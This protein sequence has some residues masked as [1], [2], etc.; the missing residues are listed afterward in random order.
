MG[1]DLASSYVGCRVLATGHGA[2]LYSY[3]PINFAGIADTDTIWPELAAQAGYHGYLHPYVQ[4]PLWAWGL[5]PLCNHMRYPAFKHLFLLLALLSIAG[6]VLLTAHYWTPRLFHPVALAV[7]FTVL[8]FSEPFLFAMALVQTHALLLLLTVAGL[9]LAQ[10]DRPVAAGFC[11]AFAAAVK[12]TPGVVVLYWLAA[13]R[14]RAAASFL[15]WSVALLVL[16]RVIAGEP[17]FRAYLADMHRTSQVLLVAE[18]NQSLAAWWMGR[19]FSPDE[20]FDVNAFALPAALRVISLALMALFAALG[21]WLDHFPRPASQ[22]GRDITHFGVGITLVAMT[23]FGPIAWT[24]YFV[25]LALPLM[26]LAQAA[27]RRHSARI[28]GVLLVAIVAITVLLFR[29]LAPDVI[30]M[31]LS[32]FAVLRGDFFSGVLAL[33]ALLFA[34]FLQLRAAKSGS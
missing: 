32:D 6:C 16:T 19:F 24:H 7:V 9:V 23:I 5:R 17:L 11:V 3:D 25:V 34:G 1:D 27:L 26:M 12:I 20:V 21:G 22:H 29:P 13:R 4:T 10:R 28:T 30:H 18:N 15:L 31:D 8:F 33:C 14:Q 2:S